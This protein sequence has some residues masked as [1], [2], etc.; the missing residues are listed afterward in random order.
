MTKRLDTRTDTERIGDE[1][2]PWDA[3]MEGVLDYAD[4]DSEDQ[5][6][7]KRFGLA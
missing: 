3:F 1:V 7:A 6:R 4:L 5:A 2:D